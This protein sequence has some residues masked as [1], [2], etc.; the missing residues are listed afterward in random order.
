M[1]HLILILIIAIAPLTIWCQDAEAIKLENTPVKV[2]AKYYI[3][4]ILLRWGPITEGHWINAR[5]QGYQIRRKELGIEDSKPSILVADY[6]PW[7]F[8]KYNSTIKKDK[9]NSELM[10]MGE[11]LY[12]EWQ[13]LGRKSTGMK[14]WGLKSDELK[15]K[16]LAA[17]VSA[18][19]N[20]EA[21][22]SGGLGYR[23]STVEAGK[24]YAYYITINGYDNYLAAVKVAN[25]SSEDTSPIIRI[26]DTGERELQVDLAWSRLLYDRY[27]TSYHIETATDSLGDYQRITNLPYINTM[28]DAAQVDQSQIIYTHRLTKN[29]SPLYYRVRGIDAFGLL[30]EPSIPVKLMGRDRTPP[31]TPTIDTIMTDPMMTAMS[32]TWHYSIQDDDLEFTRIKRSS[33]ATGTY[34]DLIDLPN[35]TTEYQDP[36]S[37][38]HVRYYYKVCAVDTASNI[39]CGG[40]RLGIINDKIAPATPTNIKATIDSSGIVNIN[41]KPN[42]EKHVRGYYIQVSNGKRRAYSSLVSKPWAETTFIDTITLNTLTEDIYYRLSAV[43][44]HNN[45]SEYSENIRLVKPDTIPPTASVIVKYRSMKNY[46]ELDYRLSQSADAERFILQRTQGKSEWVDIAN[47]DLESE[48]YRDTTVQSSTYYKYR[49]ATWDDADN[50]SR[51]FVEMKVK[52]PDTRISLAPSLTATS[53]E[54]SVILKWDNAFDANTKIAIYKGQSEDQLRSFK[55]VSETNSVTIANSPNSYFQIKVFYQDGKYSPFS[56][57]VKANH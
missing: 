53:E 11:C 4:D 18:D 54:Q 15:S 39:A 14:D 23:D 44:Y 48:S 25:T 56:N 30:S 10:I 36:I 8:D 45:L 19:F 5:N 42:E 31:K 46:I 57:I 6:K 47:L 33:H 13:T 3:G 20:F 51:D 38:Q 32:L 49:I 22:V 37:G 55:T 27:Y 2:I 52:S 16:Y 35:S 29:Y 7:S 24:Q 21:A 9:S 1:K 40:A 50:M 41:W 26:A 43:D 17:M 34:I 12:G 28:T